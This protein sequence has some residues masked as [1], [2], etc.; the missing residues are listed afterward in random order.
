M[1]LS[2]L[3]SSPVTQCA[4]IASTKIEVIPKSSLASQCFPTLSQCGSCPAPVPYPSGEPREVPAPPLL[5]DAFV[6]GAQ[7]EE[8]LAKRVRKGHLYFLASVFTNLSTS[9]VGQDFFFTP[10]PKNILKQ[11]DK[12]DLEYPLS[13][14]VPF[15]EH[16]N[17]IRRGS[18]ASTIKCA[19]ATFHAITVF[20]LTESSPETA[21]FTPKAIRHC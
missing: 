8:D 13:K 6:Q 9:T 4:S 20:G 10:L 3:S 1:L 11:A 21:H 17:T 15:T 2:N 16:K 14:I 7:I 19:P 5:I 12:D 18:I